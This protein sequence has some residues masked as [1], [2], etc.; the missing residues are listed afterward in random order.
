VAWNDGCL[1]RPAVATGARAVVFPWDQADALGAALAAARSAVI[2]NLEARADAVAL[3]SDWEG[4]HR[5]EFDAERSSHEAV[6][7]A[8]GLGTA[9]AGLRRAWD[10]AAAL[11]GTENARAPDPADATAPPGR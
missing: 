11:Q 5:R 2:A 9:L 1:P 6:L 3:L 10:D 4:G 7:S 8:D